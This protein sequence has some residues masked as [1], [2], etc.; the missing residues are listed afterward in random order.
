MKYTCVKCLQESIYYFTSNKVA[1]CPYCRQMYLL[2]ASGAL[3]AVE[4]INALPASTSESK[5]GPELPAESAESFAD[6]KGLRYAEGKLRWD[7]IPPEAMFELAFLYQNGAN[8]YAERNWERGMSWMTCFRAILS[9]SFKW[10][11]GAE[12]DEEMKV[13]HMTCVAWNAMALVTYAYR[14][15]GQDNRPRPLTVN[16]GGYAQRIKAF[17]AQTPN[18]GKAEGEKQ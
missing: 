16:T 11:M 12:Y 17:L 8:K 7:L 5:P 10:L 6:G 15:I 2:S 13:H 4:E 3:T 9:H 14:G 18:L 1:Y